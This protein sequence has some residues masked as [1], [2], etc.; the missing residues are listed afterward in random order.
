MRA[1]AVPSLLHEFPSQPTAPDLLVGLLAHL[2]SALPG[3]LVGA[4]FSNPIVRRQGYALGGVA[5]CLL[6]TIPADDL[7]GVHQ[8]A[9]RLVGHLTPPMLAVIRALGSTASAGTA[10]R[11]LRPD[12]L[13]A[14]AFAALAGALY[15]RLA[16]ARS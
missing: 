2:T 13:G 11:L 4:L 16:R 12:A 6:L 15:L 9:A 10:A 5:L 1:M 3:V 8:G 14:A 7:R